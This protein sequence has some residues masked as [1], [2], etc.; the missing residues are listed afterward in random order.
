M[1]NQSGEYRVKVS[2]RNNLI[3]TAIEEAGYTSVSHFCRSNGINLASMHNMIGLKLSPIGKG[4]EFCKVAKQTMEALC[5]CPTDLWTSE[6]LNMSISSNAREFSVEE[7]ELLKIMTG[8]ISD[9]LNGDDPEKEIKHSYIK[10]S[11]NEA[12]SSL[13][14]REEEVLKLR[15]GID[16]GEELTL[17]EVG[18]HFDVS[19]ERIR[20]MEMKALRKLRHPSRAKRLIEHTDFKDLEESRKLRTSTVFD[21]LNKRGKHG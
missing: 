16:N 2:V 12:I 18:H 5:L 14:P 4:G 19:K 9:M 3:L 15:F 13:T 10:N 6:Q 17:E 1:A 21:D 7:D 11:V 8:G 20:Q